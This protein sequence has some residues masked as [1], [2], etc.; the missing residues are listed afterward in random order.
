MNLCGGKSMEFKDGWGGLP[1][2][3]IRKLSR[4]GRKFQ[5]INC[6]GTHTVL[7]HSS[8]VMANNL[9][10]MAYLE[11]QV[12]SLGIIRNLT[13]DQSPVPLFHFRTGSRLSR[14]QSESSSES[15]TLQARSNEKIWK[16]RN[17][18]SFT[19]KLNQLQEQAMLRTDLSE[20]LDIAFNT[21]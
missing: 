4:I 13:S 7:G 20:S 5:M 3:D 19:W 17:D 10:F 21:N 16:S 12:K 14:K 11:A 1:R 18:E 15:C 6:D 2:C 9:V 8:A